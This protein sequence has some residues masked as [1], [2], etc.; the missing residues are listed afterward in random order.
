MRVVLRQLGPL[1]STSLEPHF[2]RRRQLW[3]TTKAVLRQEQL[4]RKTKWFETL[5]A[6]CSPAKRTEQN[7]SSLP[8][9]C[10]DCC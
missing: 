1:R 10:R 8:V 7:R 6:V 2:R 9:L 3:R 4:P 5:L